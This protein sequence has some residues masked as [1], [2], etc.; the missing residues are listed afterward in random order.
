LFLCVPAGAGPVDLGPVLQRWDARSAAASSSYDGD[1]PAAAATDGTRVYVT[2][3]ASGPDTI[4]YDASDG[5]VVWAADHD[6]AWPSNGASALALSPG[7]SRLFVTGR[8]GAT[9]YRTIAYDAATGAELW[10]ATYD[11]PAAGPDT[12]AALA[13]DPDG[14]RVYVTGSSAGAGSAADVATI[15]Y[16]AGTGEEMWIARYD[17]YRSGDDAAAALAVSRDGT[18][19]FVAGYA[20]D[21]LGPGVLT[22]EY[23]VLAYNAATGSRSWAAREGPAARSDSAFDIAVSSSGT[24]VYAAGAATAPVTAYDARTGTPVWTARDG[25]FD[26]VYAARAMRIAPD[27]GRLYVA[28]TGS[29]GYTTVAYE[30]ASG[31]RVWEAR[32][33]SGDVLWPDRAQDLA[34]SPDGSRAY[35]TGQ[36]HSE[37]TT[38]DF[39]T[40]A[41]D[42]AK[43]IE[44]WT[45]RYRGQPSSVVAEDGDDTA[46]A[47]AVAPDGRRLFVTGASP[48]YR[49]G[50]TEYATVAYCA[51]SAP[52]ACLTPE[53]G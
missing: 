5:S 51:D 50:P 39:A 13:V 8:S 43:G 9:D 47:L 6:V 36:S 35:V 46:T 42:T 33:N 52:T 31:A 25:P 22:G 29:G 20:N 40:V 38:Y 2:G 21:D 1:R 16:D 24:L 11:G 41:Y 32:S 26:M 12:A 15:A 28:G 30:P 27:G 14:A 48:P 17:G 3:L 10:A 53:G 23:L 18:G 34:L 19:V 7:A 4:A 45:A 49:W 44:L 37:V